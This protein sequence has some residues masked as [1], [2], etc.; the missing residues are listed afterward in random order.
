M[1]RIARWP[2]SSL[3][4]RPQRLRRMVICLCSPNDLLKLNSK[5]CRW[6]TFKRHFLVQNTRNAVI[7]IELSSNHETYF[8][9]QNSPNSFCFCNILKMLLSHAHKTI[10][11]SM[12]W[13]V[14]IRIDYWRNR[15]DIQQSHPPK[16]SLLEGKSLHSFDF[17]FLR[18]VCFVVYF[19][20]AAPGKTLRMTCRR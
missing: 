7:C 1:K 2:E 20:H 18:R 14:N 19:I 15:T 8:H 5:R 16:G 11:K 17:P 13:N 6:L 10:A 3:D 9:Q 12:H 4:I